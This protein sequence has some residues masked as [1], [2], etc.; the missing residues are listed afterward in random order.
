MLLSPLSPQLPRH[1]NS[2][3]PYEEGCLISTHIIHPCS[4]KVQTQL[5]TESE[6]T[7]L[8]LVL[9]SL[10]APLFLLLSRCSL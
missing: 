2:E 4:C 1:L 8:L 9:P 10:S 7:S 6:E 5:S 3:S